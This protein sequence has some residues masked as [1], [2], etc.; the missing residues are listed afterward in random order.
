MPD[1]AAL[2]SLLRLALEDR[3]Q[4]VLENFALRHR[5]AVYKRSVKRPRIEDRD[6]FF[7]LAVMR[8]LKVWREALVI[9]MRPGAAG[10]THLP[11]AD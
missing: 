8:M 10:P 2:L 6:R 3:Q 1:P 9:V 7:W 5:L 4:L 11:A